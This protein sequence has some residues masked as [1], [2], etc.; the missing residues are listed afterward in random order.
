MPAHQDSVWPYKR[1]TRLTQSGYLE[2]PVKGYLISLTA[3]IDFEHNGSNAPLKLPEKGVTCILDLVRFKIFKN[4]AARG[5]QGTLQGNILSWTRGVHTAAGDPLPS[6]M[7]DPSMGFSA[8]D[9]ELQEVKA[10][11]PH[12]TTVARSPLPCQAVS[13]VQ[14]LTSFPPSDGSRNLPT[15]CAEATR[16]APG[17]DAGSRSTDARAGVPDP[18]LTSQTRPLSLL[19]LGCVPSGRGHSLWLRVIRGLVRSTRSITSVSGS[20]TGVPCAKESPGDV[21]IPVSS[22]AQSLKLRLILAARSA[23]ASHP[24]RFEGSSA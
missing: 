15:L 2:G 17:P 8:E 16:Q 9:A 10:R 11:R 4:L 7:S 6:L 12:H 22:P 24:A 13:I 23:G 21:T 14:A 1:K 3:D 20:S 5:R 18:S 19:A